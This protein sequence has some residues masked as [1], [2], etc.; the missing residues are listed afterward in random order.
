MTPDAYVI[1]QS[2]C[3]LLIKVPSKRGDEAYFTKTS[4]SFQ[5]CEGIEAI[6]TNPVTG[7]IVFTH[8]GDFRTIREY[9]E[10]RNLFTMKT[11]ASLPRF[12]GRLKTRFNTFDDR[13]KR[14]TGKEIDISG[15]ASL[16][17]LGLGV[18]QITAGN[19]QAMP[20]HAAFWY[21]LNLFLMRKQPAR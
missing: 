13:I 2:F 21:A 3:F 16:T 17:L 11:N 19:A 4:D 20:W 10:K 8:T 18:S 9:G 1:H 5:G 15:I 6:N 7:S 14:L 12:N